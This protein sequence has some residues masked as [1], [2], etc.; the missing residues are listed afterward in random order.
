MQLP[1]GPIGSQVIGLG[2][3]QP[4]NSMTNRDLAK[5]VDT[6]DDWTQ[7]RTG[8]VT[9]HISEQT[10]TV[11]DMAVAAGRHALNDANV[12][13]ELVDLIIVATT[14][15]TER[16][17][18]TAGRVAHALSALSP[19]IID[20]NTACSG[21]CHALGLADSAIRTG[22]ATVALVIAAEQLSALTD[23]TDRG[24]CTLTADGSGA[25]IVAAS[26]SPRISAVNWGS[27]HRMSNT[28]GLQAPMNRFDQDDQNGLRWTITD[29]AKHASKVIEQAGYSIDDID[30]LAAQQANL[31]TIEPLAKHLGLDHKIVLTDASESG[32]TSAAS[33]PLGLSKWWHNGK[34]PADALTLLLGFG[35]GFAYAGQLIRTPARD[36]LRSQP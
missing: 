29:A 28:T 5:M 14:T 1:K 36:P 35:S 9:R 15:A 24:T 34:V 33:I 32:N 30:V 13:I 16:T 18:N 20:I 10:E 21:F 4:A 23:W 31:R 17:P 2:H 25:M 6:S 8:I 12:D 19:A 3:Y 7:S 11:A 27:D 22:T 26:D